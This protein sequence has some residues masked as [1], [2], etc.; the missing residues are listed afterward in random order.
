MPYV[1]TTCTPASAA[2][3]RSAAGTAAPAD[4]HRA[5]AAQ[6]LGRGGVVEQPVQLGRHQRDVA[7]LPRHP[8]GGVDQ[9]AVLHHRRRAGEDRAEQHLQ[10]GDVGGRQVEQ[11]LAVA[12]EPGR[13]RGRRGPQRPAREQHA[14]GL[15]GRP[16]RRHDQRLRLVGPGLPVRQQAEHLVGAAGHGAEAAHGR[17]RYACE[18]PSP[19]ATP[20]QWIAGARPRTLPAA[21][22][23][24]LAGTGV[25]AYLDG[26]RLVE[27]APGAGRLGRPAGRGQLRQR[28]LRRHPRHR[29]RPRRPDAPG[30]LRRRAAR[31]GQAGGLPELR[32]GLPRR[33]RAR[34]DH[35]LVAGGARRR[36]RGGRVVLHRRHRSPTATRRSARSWC[37][38]SSAWSR[39]SARRTCRPA[40]CRCRRG[41]PG[42]AI[43]ALACAILV[44]NNLRDVPTDR[45]VGKRTLAVVLGDEHTRY[46]FTFLV[47]L[48]A[49]MLV[50][51]ALETS[52][53]GAGG[54]RLPGPGGPGGAAGARRCPRPGA[55]PGAP[56]RRRRRAGLRDRHLALVTAA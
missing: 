15:A 17:Q 3:S 5:E 13:R 28:L 52:R 38:S 29:R 34:R 8:G 2:R 6:R 51:V 44:A 11:P 42:Q 41:T 12:A 4:Q 47:G 9:G 46:L 43:G 14:L 54:L 36:L 35:E 18:N 33:P 56:G 25:A 50:G 26:E 7:P 37:S 10:A 55:G 16:R 22:A 21:V 39:S 53:L 45:E 32:G 20:D 40:R 24:V 48:A 23:P 27:G 1:A 31:G 19:V 49:I 30:R